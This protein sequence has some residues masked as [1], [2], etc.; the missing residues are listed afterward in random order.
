MCFDEQSFIKHIQCRWLTLIPAVKRVLNQMEVIEEYFFKEVPQE[1]RR[2]KTVSKLEYNERYRRICQK[3]KDSNV[4]VQLHFLSSLE[5]IFQPLLTLFQKEEP[6]VHVLFDQLSEFVRTMM[7]RFLKVEAVGSSKGAQLLNVDLYDK[8]NQLSND[9]IVVGESARKVAFKKMRPETWI[10]P[11]EKVR[12]FYQVA[13]KYLTKHLPLKQK[14]LQDLSV[15]HPLLQ[16]SES[17]ADAITRVATQMPFIDDCEIESIADDWKMYQSQ[18]IP[19]NWYIDPET[20]MYKRIDTFWAAVLQQKDS[21]GNLRYRALS[22]FVK[23]VLCLAHGNADV[24]RSLSQNKNTVTS[25]RVKLSDESINGL[26]LVKDAVNVV[27][28]GNVHLMPITPGMIRSRK[29]AYRTYSARIAAE[30]E[31]L[32]K[33]KL[34]EEGKSKEIEGRRR[35][36]EEL[37]KRKT[38]LDSLERSTVAEQLEAQEALCASESLYS[39]AEKRLEKGIKSKDFSEVTIVHGLMEVAKQKMSNAR[40]TLKRKHEEMQ[41]IRHKKQK[42]LDKY[43]NAG[44]SS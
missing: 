21:F 35:T 23:G 7:L 24:E 4:K 8:V 31:D 36:L 37:E 9:Q 26:R 13:T 42:V 38:T 2:S 20:N 11:I 44:V 14:V 39:E 27:A 19:S 16:K 1:A 29:F 40:E 3:L 30:R 5:E 34:E 12:R 25:D 17:G 18:E 15:L 33:K 22:K 10:G 6:L 41:S 43:L 28:E 32:A